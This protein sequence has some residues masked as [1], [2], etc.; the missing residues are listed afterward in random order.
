[1][2]LSR[3]FLKLNLNLIYADK[4]I[5]EKILDY[6]ESKDHHNLVDIIELRY[7]YESELRRVQRREK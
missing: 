6:E 4:D 5:K 7:F 2:K 3:N 1:M